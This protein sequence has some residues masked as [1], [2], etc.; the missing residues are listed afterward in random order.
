M[1]ENYKNQGNK[2]KDIEG[3]MEERLDWNNEFLD[4]RLLNK[5]K[6]I[7]CGIIN[8]VKT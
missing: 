7:E 6:L 4:G 3:R 1:L 8:E 5:E 2:P